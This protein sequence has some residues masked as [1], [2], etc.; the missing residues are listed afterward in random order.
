MAVMC[1]AQLTWAC[2]LLFAPTVR[3]VEVGVLGNLAVIVL[4]AWTRLLGIPFGIAGG[5]RQAIGGWDAT[6]TLVEVAAV[7]AGLLQLAT[8]V[9]RP[10]R[11]R[12]PAR[13]S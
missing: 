13:V 1:A 11:L 2:W 9:P 6:C 4:W 5:Q 7:L 8:S 12:V 3:V 10:V